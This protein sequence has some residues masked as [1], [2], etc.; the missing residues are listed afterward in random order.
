MPYPCMHCQTLLSSF[1][2]ASIMAVPN[3]PPS[4]IT[5][6]YGTGMAY[7]NT[8]N[9]LL[10]SKEEDCGTRGG[11]YHNIGTVEAAATGS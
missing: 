5:P 9:M 1:S 10:L 11:H 2:L 4:Q 3:Y 6:L 7:L 8:L